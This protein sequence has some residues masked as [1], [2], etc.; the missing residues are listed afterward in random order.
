MLHTPMSNMIYGFSRRVTAMMIIATCNDYRFVSFILPTCGGENKKEDRRK[1][2]KGKKKRSS[3]KTTA[4][5]KESKRKVR[6]IAV[7]VIHVIFWLSSTVLWLSA[8]LL[9]LPLKIKIHRKIT[10]KISGNCFCLF[11]SV[12][13]FFFLST[14]KIIFFPSCCML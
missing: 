4:G 6:S 5:K 7:V 1:K 3:S 2:K 13:L 12:L 8:C 14:L 9:V 11:C 10:I